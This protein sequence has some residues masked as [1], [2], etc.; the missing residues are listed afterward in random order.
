MSAGS[1]QETWLRQDLAASS[2]PCTAAY[3]HKP[4]FTSGANHGPST[5][6]RPLYQALYDYNAEIVMTGHNHH[7]ERFGKMNPSGVLDNTRGIQS[8]VAGM[9][10]VGFYGFGTIQPNSLARNNDTFGVLK[11]TLHSNSWDWAFVPQA[12]KTYNDSGTGTCH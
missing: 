9:G 11:L 2:K 4:L 10:G 1:A 7:Y 6:T 3:W 12:G 5:A 8:F